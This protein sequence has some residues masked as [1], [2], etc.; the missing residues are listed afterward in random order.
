MKPIEKKTFYF[1]RHGQ[2]DANAQELM[3]GGEWDI[4]LNSAGMAQAELLIDKVFQQDEAIEKIYV[5]SMIRAQK[6]AEIL[7]T[8][9]QAPMETSESLIEW[10]VGDWERKP[11][12]DVPNPFNTTEDPTNGE[13][14]E[15]F[16]ERVIETINKFL[17]KESKTLLFVSH[18]AF[19][20]TLFTFM[21]IDPDH[22]QNATLYKVYPS[23]HHWH[24]LTIT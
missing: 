2:T 11:W 10:C 20:H 13:T 12:K 18:G 15:G 9:L 16:E 21:G 24:L 6:T 1:V 4:P 3:C 22:I 8:K 14:R 5:S 17:K 23:D 7:N 19:A